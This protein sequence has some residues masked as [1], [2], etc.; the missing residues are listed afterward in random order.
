MTKKLSSMNN[1]G[2]ENESDF[3]DEPLRKL[4]Q[5]MELKDVVIKVD[6]NGEIQEV[7]MKYTVKE[8]RK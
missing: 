8:I 4:L 3:Y 7:E 6:D 5:T 2:N 1:G